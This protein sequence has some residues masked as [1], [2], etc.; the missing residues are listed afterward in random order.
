MRTHV[1]AILLGALGLNASCGTNQNS[2][3]SSSVNQTIEKK[4]SS[5]V[6]L[7]KEQSPA[8]A[9][10]LKATKSSLDNSQIGAKVGASFKFGSNVIFDIGANMSFEEVFQRQILNEVTIGRAK[11]VDGSGD[12]NGVFVDKDTVAAHRYISC[13]SE[14]V[15]SENS[16]YG[17]GVSGGI[18][19]L[20]LGMQTNAS[21]GRKLASSTDYTMDRG[22]YY[23][24]T[25]MPLAQVFELCGDIAKSDVA[26]QN[27][28]HINDIV[29]L[30]FDQG[31]NLEDIARK[32][33]NGKKV[34]N[35]QFHN[36]KL[37]MQ[38]K[39]RKSDSIVFTVIPDTYW[40]DPI[41]LAEV[42]Y[43]KVG[44]R[45]AVQ[46]VIQTCTKDCQ[47]YHDSAKNHGLKPQP[48]SLT[49]DQAEK[50]IKLLATI[51]TATAVGS[52]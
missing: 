13:K 4:W 29:N 50:Y 8:L 7:S 3:L 15:I 16:S 44:D 12:G 38:I 20:G 27:I 39:E 18:N 22:F 21:T 47:N 11:D 10:N 24:K 36:M 52:R 51:F 37:D 33:A 46:S 34:N 1:A 25:N 45:I 19:F 9:D 42:K 23:T 14:K 30:N 31:A 49:K 2:G 41:I 17:A 32:I 26:L 28:D 5:Q 40:S 43:S 48:S 35:F 6:D